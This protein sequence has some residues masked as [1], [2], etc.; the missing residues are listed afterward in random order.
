MECES[1]FRQYE[2]THKFVGL[3]LPYHFRGYHAILRKHEAD[4]NMA[5]FTYMDFP[6]QLQ[7]CIYTMNWIERLNK[8]YKMDDKNGSIVPSDESVLF[9]RQVFAMEETE[10][11]LQQ[12]NT[13]MEILEIKERETKNKQRKEQ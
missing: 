7:R 10:T 6:V 3:M 13:S 8:E 5:Y 2:T 9:L 1:V 12:K 4:W 11:A